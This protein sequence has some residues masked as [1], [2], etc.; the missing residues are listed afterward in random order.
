[1][2]ALSAAFRRR[3]DLVV[4]ALGKSGLLPVVP[5][6]AFYALVDIGRTGRDSLSFC[7]H[8]LEA[9]SVA[10]VPGITFGPQSDRY[11]RLA[12]TIGD[13]QLRTGLI[14]LLECLT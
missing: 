13:A 5:A 14:R 6:G 9:K 8:L 11:I 10:A 4:E 12:F 1:V 7:K 3:R 2:W